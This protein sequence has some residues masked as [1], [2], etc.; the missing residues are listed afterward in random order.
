[1]QQ[2]S[3]EAKECDDFRPDPC[4]TGPDAPFAKIR[5]QREM[6]EPV[7][8]RAGHGVTDATLGSGIACGKH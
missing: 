5:F 4:L 3:S 6:Q 2:L 1:V 8:K 7:E